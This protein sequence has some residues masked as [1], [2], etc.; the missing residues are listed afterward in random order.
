MAIG[1][2]A[3]GKGRSKG[4]G[5]KSARREIKAAQA[6]VKRCF[7]QFSLFTRAELDLGAAQVAD[8]YQANQADRTLAAKLLLITTARS[9]CPE[10][11]KPSAIKRYFFLPGTTEHCVNHFLADRFSLSRHVSDERMLGLI[12]SGGSGR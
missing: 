8:R 7:R 3:K 6:Y 1:R 2:R 4:K 11:F 9:D 5:D 10:D 12:E